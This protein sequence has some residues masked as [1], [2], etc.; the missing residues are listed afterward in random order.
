MRRFIVPDIEKVAEN[1]WAKIVTTYIVGPL[2]LVLLAL[3]SWQLST[4]NSKVDGAA[5][6]AD[7]IE[8]QK[9]VW[10]AI[11]KNTEAQSTT[12]TTM[13]TITAELKA[14]KELDVVQA[15]VAHESIQALQLARGRSG[16]SSP[17]PAANMPAAPM[18]AKPE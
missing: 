6:K 17:T 2:V 13:A 3:A 8:A 16:S 15:Q 14:H 11:S 7:F 12:A 5:A 9:A 4:M 10:A 1:A 18:P